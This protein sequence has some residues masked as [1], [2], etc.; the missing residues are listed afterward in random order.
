MLEY[1]GNDEEKDMGTVDS[2][3][4]FLSIGVWLLVKDQQV[5]GA[6]PASS[7]DLLHEILTLREKS[8]WLDRELSGRALLSDTIVDENGDLVTGV[9]ISISAPDWWG[10]CGY[11]RHC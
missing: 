3:N 8:E 6:E 10:K 7:T 9:N 2:L 1:R 5:E 11:V 4:T